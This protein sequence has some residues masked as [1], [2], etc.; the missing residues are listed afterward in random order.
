MTYLIIGHKSPREYANLLIE[1]DLI[2][3][4]WQVG[5]VAVNDVLEVLAK[6]DVEWLQVDLALY[7]LQQSIEL[8]DSQVLNDSLG[9][10]SDLFLSR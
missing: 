4:A 7:N 6:A 2:H 8:I 1:R 3:A 10:S 5:A 9:H